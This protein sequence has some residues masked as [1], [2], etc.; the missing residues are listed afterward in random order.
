[1]KHIK[2]NRQQR[3][4]IAC[5]LFGLAGFYGFFIPTPVICDQSVADEIISLNVTD[6]PLGEVLEYISIAADCQFSIDESWEDYPV[7]ASFDGEPLNRI[8]KQIFWN[9]NN[10]VV[11]GADRT[12]SIIIYDEGTRSGGSI[13][14]TATIQSSQDSIQQ[15]LPINEATAPQPE[16]EISEDSGNMEKVEQQPEASDESASEENETG[17]ENKE[18][19]DEASGEVTSE[20]TTAL[21]EPEENENDSDEESNQTEETE[22]TSGDSDN[23]EIMESSEESNVN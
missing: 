1:M 21:L 12:I 13:G 10:A 3:Y 14:H 15:P 16:L 5:F 9:I 18:A 6:R 20:G 23:S 19:H 22:S 8:L 2:K 11:Y 4:M 7:T 17:A